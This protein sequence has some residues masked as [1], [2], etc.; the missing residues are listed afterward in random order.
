MHFSFFSELLRC[1]GLQYICKPLAAAKARQVF[2]NPIH[3][4]QIYLASSWQRT[5]VWIY[6]FP[7]EIFNLFK[8][9]SLESG[10]YTKNLCSRCSTYLY[11]AL[12]YVLF[13]ITVHFTV[14]K[15]EPSD[16]SCVRVVFHVMGDVMGGQWA[17]I[18]CHSGLASLQH[19]LSACPPGCVSTPLKEPEWSTS[20]CFLRAYMAVWGISKQFTESQKHRIVG[21]G[22]DLCGSSSQTPLSKQ[23][24]LQ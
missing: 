20:G 12:K 6:I 4:V 14:L 10:V 11:I 16:K 2:L 17:W 9:C 15:S 13:Q 8:K 19:C 7:N 21:V 1:L 22:R 3:T 5:E 18:P 24:H 23:G